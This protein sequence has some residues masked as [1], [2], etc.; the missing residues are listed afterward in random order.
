LPVGIWVARA[1]GG[2]FVYANRAFAQIMGTQVRADAT[3]GGYAEPYG[4]H[5]RSG[6]LYPEESMPFVQALREQALV[7]VDDIVIHRTDGD[8]VYIRAYAQPVFH[9]GPAEAV[10]SHVI[11]AFFDITREVLAE[12]E[13]AEAEAQ[14]RRSQRM[15]SIG[16]LAGGVAHDFNNLLG[17]VRVIATSLLR[18]DLDPDM[19]AALRTIDSA[20]QSAHDLTRSLL[21]FAGAPTAAKHEPVQL[22]D[23]VQ[24]VMALLERALDPRHRVELELGHPHAVAGDPAGLQQ[25]VMNLVLNARDAMPEGGRIWVRTFNRDRHTLLTVEDEGPGIAEDIRD[26][27]FEPYFTTRGV[28]DTHGAGLGLAVVYG[29]VTA[30]SG[31]VG[32][33]PSDKGALFEVALP[34]RSSVMPEEPHPATREPVVQVACPTSLRV[35]VVD[36]EPLV[37]RAAAV[38]LEA[39]G[40]EPTLV[41]RG[42]CAVQVYSTTQPRFD[43]VLLDLS[44]PDMDGRAT[45]RALQELDADVR[46]VLAT[47]YAL[48][49]DARELMQLG[50]R[51]FLHKPYALADLQEALRQATLPCAD[52]PQAG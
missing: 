25:V 14:L 17:A 49:A 42:A 48:N 19:A 21:G 33:L 31:T 11:V 22:D 7:M 20:T 45:F 38:A 32:V 52:V 2:E 51:A 10:V 9:A 13:R 34:A 4:I 3:A 37:A 16:K 47:G 27:V 30:H 18:R 24:S 43:A 1:P 46:V 35:L 15:E 50:V 36:D 28:T 6:A 29:I 26:R 44:M 39:L 12:R 23:I 5:N 40:A 8:R 41:H